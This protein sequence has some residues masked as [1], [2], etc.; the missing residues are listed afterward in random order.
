MKLLLA[1]VLF[2]IIP[3]SVNAQ[4]IWRFIIEQPLGHIRE[5]C[6]H[7]EIPDLGCVTFDTARDNPNVVFCYLHIRVTELPWEEEAL[8]QPLR[9]QCDAS[10]EGP[11]R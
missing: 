10:A 11:G 5:I 9:P 3:V 4:E 6:S 8:L 7:V 2:A 1:L